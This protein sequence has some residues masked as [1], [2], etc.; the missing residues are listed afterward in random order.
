MPA[1]CFE[2]IFVMEWPTDAWV[3]WEI[4]SL[5]NP[6]PVEG[7]RIMFSKNYYNMLLPDQTSLHSVALPMLS[8]PYS[9]FWIFRN[10]KKFKNLICKKI[11][12]CPRLSVSANGWEKWASNGWVM[13]KW[14]KASI[15]L[16]NTTV[17]S[18]TWHTRMRYSKQCLQATLTSIFLPP[19]S[20]VFFA[21]LSLISFPYYLGAWNR[22]RKY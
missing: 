14:K 18:P 11:L 19:T 20:P 12:A 17:F 2:F 3:G 8:T 1:C 6:V 5:T 13:S 21:Q 15:L 22:P 4:Q 9:I 16:T 10:K 7:W